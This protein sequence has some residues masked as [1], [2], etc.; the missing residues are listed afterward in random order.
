MNWVVALPFGQRL[1]AGKPMTQKREAGLVEDDVDLMLRV[2]AGDAEAFNLLM[3]R[4]QRTV[5]NLIFRFTGDAENAEDLAQEVFLRIYRAA[6]RYEPKAKFFTYLYQV[7]LNLCRNERE[8]NTRRK[9]S[10]LDS[11][12]E[13]DKAWEIADPE[14]GAETLVQRQETAAQVQA[15]LQALPYEQRQL[16]VL[17]RFQD[18]GYEELAEVTAQTVSAVKAKLHRAR[19]ALK[20][21]LEPLL[22]KERNS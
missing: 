1:P 17:Q 12:G 11:R 5:V 9:A 20:K 19:L 18:L 21:K 3:D 2:K 16:L 4:Y 10:S 6:P 15:A 22:G 13:G 7:T 14:V 8:R